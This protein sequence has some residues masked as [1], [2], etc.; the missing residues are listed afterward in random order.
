[1]SLIN[2]DNFKNNE[3]VYKML[4]DLEQAIEDNEKITISFIVT[5]LS[6]KGI[7]FEVLNEG[8]DLPVQ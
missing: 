7:T 1:M 8:K 3:E 4:I 6:Q 5:K 2:K